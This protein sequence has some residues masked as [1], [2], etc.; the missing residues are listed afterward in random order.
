MTKACDPQRLRQTILQTPPLRF[1]PLPQLMGLADAETPMKGWRGA[2]HFYGRNNE[3][4]IAWKW[5]YQ[6]YSGI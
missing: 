5:K 2:T 3:R 6:Q 4:H 1:F